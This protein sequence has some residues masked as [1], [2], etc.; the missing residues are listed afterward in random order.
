[1]PFFKRGA[2]E[3]YYEVHGQGTPLYVFLRDGV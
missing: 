1:M 3:I 2:V